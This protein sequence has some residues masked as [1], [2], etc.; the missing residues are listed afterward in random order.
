MAGT[1]GQSVSPSSTPVQTFVPIWAWLLG[2]P[3]HY[4]EGDERGQGTLVATTRS[5]QL[6]MPAGEGERRMRNAT[7]LC[8]MDELARDPCGALSGAR[9]SRRC[10]VRLRLWMCW[11]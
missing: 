10:R 5:T 1:P 7:A 11:F 3:F 4:A 2:L 6:D 9:G 8:R